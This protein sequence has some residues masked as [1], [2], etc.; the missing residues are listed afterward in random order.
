[1]CEPV[2]HQ[3]IPGQHS[4]YSAEYGRAAGGVT[5]AV[6]KSGSNAFHGDAFFFDRDNRLGARNPLAFL[7]S[8]DSTTGIT[9]VTGIKPTDSGIVLVQISAARLRR[10]RLSSFSI[11]TK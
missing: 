6:T 10:T 1:M 9:T 4:N 7:R 5:N 2:G 3:R 8:F 11:M